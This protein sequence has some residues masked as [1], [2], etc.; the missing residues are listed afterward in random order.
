MIRTFRVNS[1]NISITTTTKQRAALRYE[2]RGLQ[3][4]SHRQPMAGNLQLISVIEAI[5]FVL[6]WKG[7]HLDTHACKRNKH[8]HAL[9]LS[10]INT[11]ACTQLLLHTHKNTQAHKET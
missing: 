6:L 3:I 7:R 8:K 2:L 4:E 9:S 10:G 1:I 11:R 5:N